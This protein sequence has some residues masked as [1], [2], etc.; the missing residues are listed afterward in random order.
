M[1]GKKQMLTV[2]SCSSWK[3]SQYLFGIKIRVVALVAY[4]A[5]KGKCIPDPKTKDPKTKDP[6]IKGK[7]VKAGV[8]GRCSLKL[9]WGHIIAIKLVLVYWQAADTMC[10]LVGI[11]GWYHT[12]I[13]FLNGVLG[14]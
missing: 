4:L 6:K 2:Y 7:E 11:V 13:I 5:I 3:L 9:F 8:K 1:K 10:L 12:N 14:P